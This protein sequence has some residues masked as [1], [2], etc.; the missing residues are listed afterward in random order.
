MVRL[1]KAQ[2]LAALENANIEIPH[3]ATHA[4]L[5]TIYQNSEL[6]INP[7]SDAEILPIAD[8]EIPCGSGQN[9][10]NDGAFSEPNSV[11]ELA[12][13]ERQRRV[14]LLRAE[15]RELERAEQKERQA[16]RFE[17]SDI[18]CSISKFSGDDSYSIK[19]W[20]EN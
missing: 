13:L 20:I 6:S 10:P 5:T 4:E 3:H 11:D 15:V 14:L 8:S 19:K 2:L 17:F 12:Q 18:E 7:T 16:S 1:T 9:V